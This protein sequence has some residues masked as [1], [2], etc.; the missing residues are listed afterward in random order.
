MT[1]EDFA[2]LH[3]LLIGRLIE[4]RWV[5]VPTEDK[6]RSRNGAYKYMGTAGLVQ[7]WATMTEPAVWRTEGESKAGQARVAQLAK[8]GAQEAAQQ[9]RIAAGKAAV[10]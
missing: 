5:R 8:Q 7:N 4:A 6:P 3:G 1:F 10:A 2:K 9:A